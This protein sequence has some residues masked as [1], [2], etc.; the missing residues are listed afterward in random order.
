VSTSYGGGC[1]AYG[2]GGGG[3]GFTYQ[4]VPRSELTKVETER[5]AA[6]KDSA[7]LREEVEFLKRV[8]DGLLGVGK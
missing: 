2:A 3:G 4:P 5:D 1:P 7:K 8:V 6:R